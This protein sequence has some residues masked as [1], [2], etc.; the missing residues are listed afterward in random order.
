MKFPD[1]N[2][3]GGQHNISYGEF[4]H[5]YPA[6]EPASNP[7]KPTKVPTSYPHGEAAERKMK[8]IRHEYKKG[9]LNIGKSPKKV[10][11]QEQMV[12][13]MLSEGR[14]AQGKSRRRKK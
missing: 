2:V 4:S 11:T 8:K 14:E 10:K 12:A 9:E 5:N 3:P 1:Y 13:I 7:G 6:Q